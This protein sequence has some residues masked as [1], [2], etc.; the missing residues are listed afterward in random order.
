MIALKHEEKRKEIIDKYHSKCFFNNHIILNM[1]FSDKGSLNVTF[2]CKDI[3]QG[4]D[5]IMH[6]G[7]LSALYDVAMVQCLF[8]H[9]IVAMTAKLNIRF[10]K[11]V[12]VNK[13]LILKTKISNVIKDKFYSMK[14]TMYQDG[15]KITSAEAV[16]V[17]TEL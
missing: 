13:D 15:N 17:K 10:K 7:V 11:S 8:G 16:F 4:Y 2:F 6:G 3:F 9:G 5:N 14:G 12:D 1:K